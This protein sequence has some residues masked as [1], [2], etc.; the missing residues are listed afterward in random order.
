MIFV[1]VFRRL[2]MAISL[3][4]R[5]A[6]RTVALSA[7]LLAPYALY[8]QGTTATL[9]GTVTDPTGAVVPNAV[10]VLKNTKSTD[11]RTSKSG[12]S[13]DFSFSAVPVGDYEVDITAAGFK[14]YKLAG[15]HLDPGDTR[16][17]REVQ[18][19]TGSD[20]ESVTVNEAS[21]EITV[22]SGEQSSLI[23][24]EDI[25]HL[26]VEGR[27][28]T[29]LLK[30]LPGFAI[31]AG[32]TNTAYDPSQV[33][34]NGALGSYNGNGTTGNSIALLS[35]GVDITDP[36]NFGAAIQN[37]NYDFVAEVKVQ[38][39]SFGADE[40]RGPIVID[41]VGQSGG[42]KYHGSLYT[43]G[44]TN[45][46]DSTDWLANNT[47]QQKAP[48][49]E[50]YPGFT[51]GGPVLIPGLDF[52]RSK[53]LTFW[54]G[55]ED[56]AQRNVYAYGGAAGAILPALVPTAN[57]RKGD[58]SADEL[59]K[60][61]GN[62][63]TNTGYSNIAGTPVTDLSGATLAT[64]GQL[65]TINPVTSQILNSLPLPNETSANG[66]NY[67]TT[68]L[69]DNDLWQ[70]RG[71]VDYSINDKNKL[72]VVYSKEAG[73]A[74]V[75][76]NEYYSPRGNLGGV[77]VPGGGLLSDINSEIGSLNYTAIIS[78]KITNELY[79]GGSWLL[80]NFVA[81]SFAATTLN[82]TYTNTGLFNNGSKVF[83]QL[84]DY[85]NDGLPLLL[86][87]DTT[88]GGIYA[89]KWVRTGGDNLTYVVGKHTIRVGAFGQL[90]TN[91]EVN[92]FQGTNG[93]LSLYYFGENST[94]P[95]A[96]AV[97][98][99]GAQG[100]GNGGNYLA[101]FLEGGVQA[102]N[103]ENITVAPNI[104]FWNVDAYAQDHWRITPHL[105]ID[106]GVRF[107]HLTPWSDPHGIGIPVFSPAAYKAG[108]NPT[109]PGFLWHAIDPSIPLTGLST[110]WAYVEPR[111]GFAWDAYG[112]GQ[113][114]VRGGF[115]IYRS[116]DSFNDAT[117]GLAAVEGQRSANANGPLLLS[118]LSAVAA[119][120]TAPGGFAQGGSGSGFMQG[121]DQQPQVYTYNFA[122]DQ[123]SVFHSLI[124]IAYIGNVSKHLLNNGS[125]LSV[126]L[127]NIN[128]LPI[129]SLYKP[130][131]VTGVTLPLLPPT[132]TAS[133]TNAANSISNLSAN[134]IDQWRPYPL[135]G[136]LNVA[137]H[138][139]Y[140]SYNSLQ[141]VWN[142][143]SGHLYYGINYTFSKAL[144]VLGSDSNGNPTDPFNYRNDYL[145][146]SFDRTHIFNVNYSYDIPNLVKNKFLGA[147][148]NGVSISGITN[149]Q[150][151]GDFISQ[152]NSNFGL[153]G[154]L[155]TFN[156]TGQ[157]GTIPISNTV[158]LGTPDVNLQPRLTC[159]PSVRTNSSNYV[160]GACLAL[161]NV[162]QQGTV[163]LPYIHE[164]G[165]IK[166]DL[167]ASKN[168]KVAEGQNVQF[169]FAAYNFLNH[170]NTTFDTG[171][172][173]NNLLL[174]YNNGTATAA[175]SAQ[176]LAQALATTQNANAAV[177]GTT[178]LRT[179]PR[180]IEM[181][182][183]YTF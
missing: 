94:D 169:R 152:N 156:Q 172:Q 96:G 26:S 179:G 171:L 83:P 37:V 67:I 93:A 178:K 149:V 154:G 34:V 143:Q 100:S 62:D 22:D 81:K 118:S 24:A 42:D 150:S 99:T 123:K 13:G 114:V 158:F 180:T 56:Y 159:D 177:F 66:F 10:V 14:D 163:R 61:L 40:A 106:Y 120:V 4:T 1:V 173:P 88:F 57:M 148:V 75:P 36:G 48:D 69:I 161:P 131:P 17:L 60:Y 102:Y 115:G 15:V 90:D 142:K 91:H 145:P 153:G 51:F 109:L 77:N 19:V 111:G 160:N 157:P 53:K 65:T 79:I 176:P 151:G 130:N 45:Q 137:Q 101:N 125:N 182:L 44:R 107:D 129:G 63:Y 74:G 116:H 28:V 58:F 33:S 110:K 97:H 20:T 49:R 9:S 105:T 29:E 3:R 72:F 39:S 119:S 98:W 32:S 117:N 71:R 144:G 73:K 175:T 147:A 23:S 38:T 103:Q 43:Y 16:S 183:K 2:F 64:P 112:T 21:N 140:G 25:K 155:A 162:G 166:S 139:V 78:P 168:F 95:V 108:T 121:D 30:I 47:G 104:Y 12:G 164:P 82:G 50:V 127:D 54:A 8:A 59:S 92:A 181:S 134:E 174:N 86:L 89:K 41:A 52:N 6:S 55:A 128:A 132:G 85:G 68:N 18:L 27:D 165:Y 122:V 35:D 5:A 46:L 138:N 146:L 135:Y 141:A 113:T 133:P 70:A 126:N 31:S 11:V 136:S 80:Q 170:P 87:P 124:E 167:T 7:L 76:Q 84:Q